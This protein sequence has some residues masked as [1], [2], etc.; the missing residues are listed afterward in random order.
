MSVILVILAV[1]LLA[2]AYVLLFERE[3]VAPVSAFLG[4]ACCY[5]ASCLPLNAN[6]LLT[7]LCLTVIVTGVSLMQPR[8]VMQQRRG[9]GYITVGSLAGLAVGLLG[10]SVT[11]RLGAVYAFMVLGV[12]A[13]IFFGYYIFTRTPRG[14]AV[15]LSSGHFFSYL[16]AK[17]FPVAITTMQTGVLLVLPLA[18]HALFV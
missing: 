6:I 16:L 2:L 10:F 4:M 5:A 12:V 14:R 7:W 17:G 9:M 13:G 11:T 18:R 15:S 8:A 1:I 3:A